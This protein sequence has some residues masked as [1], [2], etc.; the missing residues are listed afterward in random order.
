[1]KVFLGDSNWPL[2]T[3]RLSME[4]VFTTNFAVVSSSIG[5]A[6]KGILCNI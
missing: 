3:C 5:I 4:V 2:F 1:M 6:G